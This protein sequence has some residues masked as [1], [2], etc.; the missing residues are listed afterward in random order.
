MCDEALREK[1]PEAVIQQ[2]KTTTHQKVPPQPAP[3]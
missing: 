1:Q 2:K 3:R